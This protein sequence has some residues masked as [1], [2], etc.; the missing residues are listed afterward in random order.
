MYFLAL[1]VVLTALSFSPLTVSSQSKTLAGYVLFASD[2]SQSSSDCGIFLGSSNTITGDIGSTQKISAG[3]TL[4]IDGS[5]HSGGTIYFSSNNKIKGNVT[6]ANRERSGSAAVSMGTGSFLSGN[7]DANGN[8]VIRGG[9]VPGKVTHPQGTTYEGP[10]PGVGD[11]IGT[12]QLPELP[13]LPPITDFPAAGKQDISN[14]QTITPGTYGNLCLKSNKTITLSG[15]GVYVFKS[16]KLGKNTRI[17]YDFKN[18]TSGKFRIYVHEDADVQNVSAFTRN[19]GDATGI[20]YETHGTGHSCSHGRYSWSFESSC[21]GWLGTIWAPYAGI[22]IGSGQ[23]NI[24][25]AFYSGTRIAC[26]DNSK[27]EYAPFAECSTPK[28]NAG[29]DMVLDCTTSTA[30]LDGSA[31]TPGL[32]YNWKGIGTAHIASDETGLTPIV[33]APGTYV[34][35][36]TNPNG[37][38]TATD[39]VLVTPNNCILP[40]YPPPGNGKIKNLIGAELNSLALHFG[41]VAD[42]A[43]YIFI[44]KHDSVMIE[45]ISLHGKYNALLS[46]LQTPDY[47]MTDLINNGPNTLIISGKYPIRNLLKLDSLPEL[48]D[49]C[50]PIFPSV[51]NSGIV[52]SQGDTAIQAYMAR[53]GYG[54]SGEGVKVGV[55]S[56]SYNT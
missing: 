23:K 8:I 32:Q 56:N 21:G 41:S 54:L 39:T 48:I 26:G 10:K 33:D 37:S 3:K 28:A 45:V 24:K 50:R 29:A 19:G 6:A 20:Y 44:L 40:Y 51:S 35:T 12:P 25:G 14:S 55:I 9:E 42:S 38:C 34:L 22:H 17:V 7:L 46:L 47:G 13:A 31:S 52:N 15:P 11:V 27:I 16:I 36:V 2:E 49:Y 30:R 53:Q 5:I 18:E 4:N 1:S 43:K